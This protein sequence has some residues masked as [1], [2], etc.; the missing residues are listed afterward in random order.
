M[1]C[2]SI[3]VYTNT[4]LKYK[5][6]IVNIQN[7]NQKCFTWSV[8]AKLYPQPDNPHRVNPYKR[9]EYNCN[10]TGIDYPIKTRDKEV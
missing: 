8:L 10:M 4:G 7:N 6:T 2:L 1:I 3:F 5:K 9:L